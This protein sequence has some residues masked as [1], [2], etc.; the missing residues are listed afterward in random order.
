MTLEECQA[1]IDN[2]T[3]DVVAR[4]DLPRDAKSLRS[5]LIYKR[6]MDS[7]G[8]VERYKA[9]LVVKGCSQRKGLDYDEVF[10]P[11]AH[12][13]TIRVVL[14]TAAAR[15]LK[16]GQ[17]DVAS[18]FLIPEVEELLFMELPRGWPSDLPGGDSNGTLVARL[19]KSIY[20]LRQASRRWAE[21]LSSWIVSVGFTR[22]LSDPC[23]Y[24]RDLGEHGQFYVTVWV[25]D[26][27]IVGSREVDIVAFKRLISAE[28][29]M[30]D[31]GRAHFCLGMRFCFGDGWVTMDQER[32]VGELLE[33]HGLATCHSVLTPLAPGTELRPADKDGS[34]D[35]ECDQLLPADKA[36]QFR[37]VVGA[38]LYLV[39]CTRPDIAMAVNQLSR[40]MA[41]PTRAH[42]AASKHVLRYLRGTASMGL[43]FERAARSEQRDE[44]VGFA[45]AS[46]MSVALTSR[47]VSGYVF[48][49]NG[50]AISW[51]CK[52][53]ST[54]AT[55]TAE[56]EFDAL[57]C[58]TRESMY[59]RGLLQEM[60][61]Q[62]RQP[63]TIF[64]DNQPCIALV[65]NP[66]TS[67]RTRHVALR[68]NF[69]R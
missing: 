53:Q 10:A 30:K 17:M 64:E 63:T 48:T 27:L 52:V 11:V 18:A 56:A 34:S 50:A 15:G 12:H 40:H 20:G 8:N 44:L 5:M 33:R 42:L 49:L 22:S 25:D 61:L 9:R 3:F 57:C 46:W 67:H 4:R 23:L 24:V 14:S 36:L 32:Y 54:I 59:L 26:L 19:N 65:Q 41:T 35:A 6:K 58:A 1:I 38:L 28:F 55:S 37:E 39:T 51:R 66:M 13:A 29:P 47:S 7:E 45:D 43:R 2:G 62:Q 68:F 16:V 60:C 69:V 21:R 31:L